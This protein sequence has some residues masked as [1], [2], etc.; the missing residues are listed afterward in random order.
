M[1]MGKG[2]FVMIRTG[3]ALALV[4]VALAALAVRQAHGQTPCVVQ[5]SVSFAPPACAPYEDRNGPLLRGD[6]LLEAPAW[7]PPGW[8]AAV[9]VDPVSPHVGNNL[10]APVTTAAGTNQVNLPNAELR[11]TVSPRFEVGYRLPEGYGEFLASYRFVEAAG[12]S[13]LPGFDAA[14]NPGA[15]H[16]RLDMNVFDL[17]FGSREIPLAMGPAWDMKW[18][19]GVRIAT[20]YFD[21]TAANVALS[22]HE[23]SHFAGAGPHAAV[24]LARSLAA[25]PGLALYS[26]L[27]G[28]VL[29]GSVHQV[30]AEA[31]TPPGGGATA[32]ETD[33]SE[34][35]ALPMVSAQA[36]LSWA[37]PSFPGLRL[38]GGYLYEGWY[39]V[40]LNVA[41]GS[42]G[43]ITVQGIFLRGEWKY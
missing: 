4:V 35:Q 24:E 7:A 2:G 14:G 18:L 27:D 29:I 5:P 31:L 36:G 11:W 34:T 15:L 6:P 23:S 20:V 30:F 1:R 13:T 28:A 32:G 37:P 16:S 42:R 39:N 3:R 38:E 40:G 26:R 22:E 43:D 21:S 17:D 10:T 8:F 9:E 33:Q 25:V 41:S 12:D 19:V